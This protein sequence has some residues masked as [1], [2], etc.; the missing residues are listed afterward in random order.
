MERVMPWSE[1]EA[2]MLGTR[3]LRSRR[4]LEGELPA[5]GGRGGEEGHLGEVDDSGSA[6]GGG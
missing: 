3:K 4:H 5:L 1:R 2:V 6:D